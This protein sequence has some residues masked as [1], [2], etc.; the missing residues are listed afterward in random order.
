MVRK[1]ACRKIKEMFACFPSDG[2]VPN[3]SVNTWELSTTWQGFG[4]TASQGLDGEGEF[5][6]NIT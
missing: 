2:G 1:T 3:G 6:I 5:A 4:K